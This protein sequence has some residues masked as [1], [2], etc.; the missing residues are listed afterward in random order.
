MEEK[1]LYQSQKETQNKLKALYDTDGGKLLVDTLMA[2]V[3]NM[4]N[5]LSS[6]YKHM[7]L[8]EFISTSADLSTKLNMV[9]SL[10]KAKKNQEVL[11]ELLKE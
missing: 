8:E 5:Q 10:T 9:R 2:Q 4:I 1:N 7:T 3:V 11:E 6:G